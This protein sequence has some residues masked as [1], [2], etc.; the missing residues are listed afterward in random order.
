MSEKYQPIPE[1]LT[2]VGPNKIEGESE[3]DNPENPRVKTWSEGF[4]SGVD[5]EVSEDLT[6]EEKRIAKD[7]NPEIQ[8]NK[9]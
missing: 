4:Y 7:E 9:S 3:E 2:P 1:N 8:S 5:K 6:E